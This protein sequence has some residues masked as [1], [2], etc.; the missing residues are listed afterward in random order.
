M[1]AGDHGAR[2]SVPHAMTR[3]HTDRARTVPPEKAET[4]RETVDRELAEALAIVRDPSGFTIESVLKL[5]DLGQR[6]A[7]IATRQDD[8]LRVELEAG[9]V[10]ER[11]DSMQA[12]VLGQRRWH[13]RLKTYLLGV[14]VA[15]AVGQ[16]MWSWLAPRARDEAHATIV[17]PAVAAEAKVLSV[18]ER[19]AANERKHDETDRVLSDLKASVERLNGAVVA[20]ASKL[21]E[22]T[23]V[24]VPSGGGK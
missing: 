12:S 24:R 11:L 2:P 3:A 21:E 8:K 22:P 19:I 4:M 10:T 7:V 18:E 23:R 16:A 6:R 9:R 5:L 17:A 15:G 20:L 13:E 14:A 1:S